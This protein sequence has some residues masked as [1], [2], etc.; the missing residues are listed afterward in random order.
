MFVFK[1]FS[2]NPVVLAVVQ[3]A[4]RRS[5]GDIKSS[6]TQC[7]C[8]ISPSEQDF[9]AFQKALASSSKII[10]LGALPASFAE[11]LGLQMTDTAFCQEKAKAVVDSVLSHNASAYHVRYGEH[12]LLSQVP[13]QQRHFERFDFTDEWNNLGYG[14]ISV[15]GDIWSLSQPLVSTGANVLAEVRDEDGFVS[16]FASVTDFEQSSVLYINRPVG[17]VDGLDWGLVEDFFVDY[18]SDELPVLPLISDLPAGCGAVASSRLDCDQSIINSKPLVD[19]YKRYGIDISLAISTGIPIAEED[20]SFMKSFAAQG[21]SL[22]SHTVTHHYGWGRDYQHAFE[23]A[24]QSKDWLEANL[25]MTIPYA[26]SPFHS[27]PSYAVQALKDAGYDGF[28][29]GIIHNDPEYLCTVSGQVPFVEG[30]MVMHAQQSMM[31]G[32]CFHRYGDSVEPYQQ[33]FDAHVK[34]GKMFGY[35]DHPFGGY[36]YGWHSEEERLE[37][38]ERLIQHI[39]QQPNVRWM[40]LDEILTFA[41][42]KNQVR[43][44][45]D[46]QGELN[47]EHKDASVRV[48]YRG[49]WH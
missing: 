38:H 11:V 44:L 2:Y 9:L 40:T 14:R 20:I 24:K 48:Y 7:F 37:A 1:F 36:D 12:A 18:R 35:L 4:L 45:I 29:S 39:N 42:H 19:L 3:L 43:M 33:A 49:E 5:F 21:G 17:L 15:S 10:V 22:L 30:D 32:D 28:I 47:F 16:V 8:F 25:N 31:H 34:A 27:N 6:S 13:Y 26:V 23:E 46:A 41:R